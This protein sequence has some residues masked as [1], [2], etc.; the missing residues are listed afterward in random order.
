MYG[1]LEEI[2]LFGVHLDVPCMGSQNNNFLLGV[3][4]DAAFMGSD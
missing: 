1:R 4:P 2:I 3:H